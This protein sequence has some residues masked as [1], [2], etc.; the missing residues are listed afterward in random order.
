[1]AHYEPP[2]VDLH[3]LPRVFEFSVCFGSRL[4]FFFFFFL[5]NFADVNFAAFFDAKRVK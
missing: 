1:M 4:F 3:C 5:R 2:Y